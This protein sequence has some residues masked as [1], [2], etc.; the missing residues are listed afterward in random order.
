MSVN[1]QHA[2]VAAAAATAVVNPLDYDE[3]DDAINSILD[4][5]RVMDK[6]QLDVAAK[7]TTTTSTRSAV[8][9]DA[10]TKMK[11]NRNST[12]KRKPLTA[13]AAAAAAAVDKP[14]TVKY[15][16][17]APYITWV[18]DTFQYTV[19]NPNNCGQTLLKLH[20]YADGSSMTNCCALYLNPTTDHKIMVTLNKLLA[21]LK[22]LWMDPTSGGGAKHCCMTQAKMP[23]C[24]WR[25]PPLLNHTAAVADAASAIHVAGVHDSAPAP[26]EKRKKRNQ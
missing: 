8:A 4:Q 22:D 6:Q 21:Q 15:P 1:V 25:K 24:A 19:Q 14:W 10:P 13:P 2:D 23:L 7:P 5:F 17:D 20:L 9:A 18:D 16:Y 3:V 11:T 12:R 26:V